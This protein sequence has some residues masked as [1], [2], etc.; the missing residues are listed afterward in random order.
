M[1]TEKITP[2]LTNLERLKQILNS[3]NEEEEPQ[4]GKVDQ[5]IQEIGWKGSSVR[6]FFNPSLIDSEIYGL[7]KWY[8]YP[9]PVIM[10]LHLS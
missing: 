4:E 10:T 5:G 8:R 2:K 7:K 3:E 9:V 6:H 1:E